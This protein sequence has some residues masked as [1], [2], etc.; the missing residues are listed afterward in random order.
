[1]KIENKA[2]LAEIREQL[3]RQW[4]EASYRRRRQQSGA[5]LTTAEFASLAPR[6]DLSGQIVE[7]CGALSSG[8]TSFL[9]RVLAGITPPPT[10]AYFDFAH[11]FFPAAA[12]QA[13]IDLERLLLLQPTDQGKALRLAEQI[14]SAEL[15][16]CLV[17]DLISM[18]EPLPRIMLHRLRQQL[19][20][21]DALLL[22]LTQSD[23]SLLPASLVSLRLEVSRGVGGTLTATVLR[24]RLSA[25]GIRLEVDADD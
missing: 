24:S 13:G 16:R 6:V 1:M 19:N 21:A 25:E 9:Y 7:I 2:T 18:S 22:L 15:A 20:R 23:H 17:F 8:K 4:P 14:L 5:I 11:S 3:H 10:I 12:L